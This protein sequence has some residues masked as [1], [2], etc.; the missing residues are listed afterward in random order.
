MKRLMFA[1]LAAAVFLFTVPTTVRADDPG[2]IKGAISGTMKIDFQTLKNLDQSGNYRDGSP[3]VGALD[4]YTTNLTVA[5]V[6]NFSGT[7]KRQPNIYKKGYG[8]GDFRVKASRVQDASLYY[9]LNVAIHNAK[10]NEDIS[11]GKW[12]GIVPINDDTGYYNFGGGNAQSSP[13]RFDIDT[14]GRLVAYRDNFNGNLIGKAADKTTLQQLIWKR[15]NPDGKVVSI[16]IKKNDPMTFQNLQVA[17]GPTPNHPGFTVNGAMNY[18]YEKGNYFID[19]LK[20]SYR[21]PKTGQDVNDV[22]S[23]T[24]KWIKDANYETNGK[25]WYQFN[26]VWN[27]PTPKEDETAV[28][29]T[30]DDESA[31]FAVDPGS[32]RLE[33]RINYTDTRVGTGDDATVTDS[34]VTYDLNSYGLSKEDV[35]RFF[36]FWMLGIG[37]ENDA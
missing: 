25:S 31:V 10:S 22:L 15:I 24:I 27:A 14:V 17:R 1:A 3:S 16:V 9:D 4:V 7:V 23:G 19:G 5:H 35:M 36:K 13:L 12:V 20:F 29:A 33:G 2:E 28:V 34:D 8:F 11:I 6:I 37:P 26:V 18:D 30:G 21:D 32:K